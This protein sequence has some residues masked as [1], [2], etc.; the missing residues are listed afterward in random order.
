MGNMIHEHKTDRGNLRG[1][2]AIAAARMIAEE[3]V[4][5]EVAKKKAARQILGNNR[6]NAKFL[7]DNNEIEDEL[8]IYNA[9]FMAETQPA[10][11][12]HLR[13]T[14]LQM[15]QELIEFQPYITGAVLNGTAGEHNDIYLQLFAES[16]KDVEIFLLNRN[17]DISVTEAHEYRGKTQAIEIIHFHYEKEVFHLT[18]FNPDD[19]RKMTRATNDQ[20]ERTDIK[21]LEQLIEKQ[22]NPLA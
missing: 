5:Y 22:V 1:E 8:R 4:T 19:M 3:G 2:I 12:L 6:I 10:R 9:L 20:A 13:R 18:V 17:I 14:A 15:M 16:A 7:P 21:G 11:L